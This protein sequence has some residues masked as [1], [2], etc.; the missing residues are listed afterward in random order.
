[1]LLEAAE[2]ESLPR[3]ITPPSPDTEK[4]VE[5]QLQAQEAASCRQEFLDR[6][7]SDHQR[8]WLARLVSTRRIVVSPMTNA[9]GYDRNQREE[10]G[11]DCN[12][13]FPFDVTSERLCMRTICGR[14]VNELFRQH[15]FQMSL[16]FHGGTEVVGYEWGA[17][18]YLHNLSPDDK[19]Q[20]DISSI[21][22]RFAGSFQGTKPYPTGTMND[23]VYA[24]HGGMEDW[25][26]AGSWIPDKVPICK[27]KTYGGYSE[28]KSVYNDSMLRAFNMLIETSNQKIPQTHLG[29]SQDLLDDTSSTH[30]GHVARN[31]RLALMA[32]ELVEP[33]ISIWGVDYIP[34]ENDIVPMTTHTS[35][36]SK[37]SK[38]MQIPGDRQE[39]TVSWFVG[40][41]FDVASTNILYAKWDDVPAVI[42]GSSQPS[43]ANMGTAFK[44]TRAS[45]GPTRWK[46]GWQFD[47]T[48][49]HEG[50]NSDL[51]GY[52]MFNATIDL[53][54]FRP[55]D[56]IA[57]FVT[58]QVDQGWTTQSNGVSPK[59]IGP[60]S[61]IVNARTNSEWRHESAGKVIQGRKDWFSIPL[62][63]LISD[64]EKIAD[65]SDRFII[66]DFESSSEF[67]N[68]EETTRE[69][70]KSISQ[71][72][73][74]GSG[75]F[76]MTFLIAVSLLCA[77]ILFGFA[78]VY[79]T[80]GRRKG[81]ERVSD[82]E[83][84]FAQQ[85]EFD[86]ELELHE[87]D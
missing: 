26:Y 30:N 78:Y 47:E 85:F 11:I 82:N 50:W 51:T 31:I 64:E 16:T 60:M 25:A 62:T 12:R 55:G 59:G 74:R 5:W 48:K 45:H 72:E 87:M 4:G 73:T 32:I 23:L 15:L 35:R 1:M 37:R 39:I 42:D 61:H 21:Y 44:T 7:I 56:Q 29:T 58:A 6:G 52:P 19:A 28:T 17:Y 20:V 33:Y 22:S 10:D 77:V 81:R 76:S 3:F 79:K 46:E 67:D 2:C 68:E 49:K 13:D 27:P 36:A 24:V 54:E 83:D 86:E 71:D 41:G 80:V 40:G 43:T 34:L 14:T 63:L 66:H 70:S 57:V 65:L 53:T 84:M 69:S 75:S 9:L 18:P 8:K 38:V